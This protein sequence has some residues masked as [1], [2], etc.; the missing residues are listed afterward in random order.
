V[1]LALLLAGLDRLKDLG[2][3]VGHAFAG[4]DEQ[5]ALNLYASAGFGEVDRVVAWQKNLI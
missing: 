5:P 1:T 3:R 4:G 2:A